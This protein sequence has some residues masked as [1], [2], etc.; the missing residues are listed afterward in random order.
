MADSINSKAKEYY[1]NDDSGGS[2]NN[3]LKDFLKQQGATGNSINTLWRS[4]AYGEGGNSLNTRLGKLWGTSGSLMKRWQDVLGLTWDEI[5]AFFNFRDTDPDFLLDGSTSFDGSNDYIDCG[6]GLGNALGDNYAGSFTV[7]MWL[8]INDTSGDVG[9]FEVGSFDPASWVGI[10]AFRIKYN[11]LSFITVWSRR[12]EVAFS[13]TSSWHHIVGVYDSRGADFTKLYVDGVS[14]GSATGSF[15]STSDLDLSG[16]KTII[17]AYYSA[18]NSMGGEIANVGIW[19][20]SLSS[21]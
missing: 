21:S 15:P 20:R 8:K 19:N 7:S 4:Y 1:D 5:K 13:D 9:A 16:K 17:G 10:F 12:I 14:V 6:T 2:L 3:N 11:T 18:S